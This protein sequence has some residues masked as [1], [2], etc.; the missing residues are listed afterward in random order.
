MRI[1]NAEPYRFSSEARAIL[2]LIGEVVDE[3][4]TR[5]QL[6][7]LVRGFD[8]L[9][10]RLGHKVDAELFSN[11][12][13]LRV[14]S[15]ATTGLNH[16]DVDSAK[17]FGVSVL[18][19]RGERQFLNSITATAEHTWG[20][21]LALVRH[22]PSAAQHVVEFCW[23]RDH[24]IGRQL[25]G[26]T[27]GI[28]GMGRL[29]TIVSEYGRAFRMKVIAYDENPVCS[30]NHVTMVDLH[31]LLTC[32]DVIVTL[33][34]YQE[35]SH[36]LIGRSEFSKMKRGAILINTSR[37]EVVDELALLEALNDE[38][39]SGAALDVLSGEAEREYGWLKT[40]PLIEF[41]KR[42]DRLI[43]TPHIGG[44]A[45]DAMARAEIFMANKLRS[46][47]K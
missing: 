22:L 27:I 46:F 47:L 11:A 1:L 4:C 14:V 42:S 45:S 41:A 12:T 24:F 30:P 40:H 10:V 7:N 13:R 3:E 23:D 36:H 28:V 33:P 17:K 5:D 39:L 6:I 8:I 35:S 34:S 2:S 44:L 32:S 21:L 19:L 26:L 38:R 20:L 25:S 43:I 18:S 16:I 29:G 15:T 9:I 31:T 37:G